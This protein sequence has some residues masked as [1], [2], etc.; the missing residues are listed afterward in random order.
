MTLTSVSNERLEESV[1]EMPRLA[2]LSDAVFAFALTLLVLDVRIP[3]GIGEATLLPSLVALLPRLLVYVFSFIVIGGA[4]GSHQRMLSQIVRGDGPLVWLNLLSLFFVTLLPA[5]SVL[6]GRFPH[7]LVPILVFAIDVILI[8]MSAYLLW[9]HARRHSLVNEAL[10]ARLVSGIGRRLTISAALFAVSI[11]LYGLGSNAVFIAWFGIAL[12]LFTSDWLSWRQAGRTRYW[13]VP[14]SGVS[15]ADVNLRHGAGALRVRP[16][17]PDD[18]L[19]EGTFGGG[20]EASCSPSA[21][22]LKIGLQIPQKRGFMSFRYPWAWGPANALDWDVSLTPSVP[23]SLFVHSAG[24]QATL[25]LRGL[26]IRNVQIEASASSTRLL[27]PLAKGQVGIAIQASV[28]SFVLEIPP[29]APARI[30][31]VRSL[32]NLTIDAVAFPPV[33]PNH[34]YSSPDFSSAPDRIDISLDVGWGSVEILRQPS[35]A[36]PG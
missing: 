16:R 17:V 32:R 34:E 1:V 14:V 33:L 5:C 26:T 12:L 18:V 15:A 25:D 24:G 6:L 11:P 19:L 21:A 30:H 36:G 35:E 27:P 7:L 4:W 29:E 20:V 2:S 28:S 3:E 10:D 13:Q 9:R 31:S 8:Q 23:L 22:H